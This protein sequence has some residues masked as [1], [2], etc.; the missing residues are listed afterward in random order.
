M[1]ECEG[2]GSP[3][4]TRAHSGQ[5][6][7]QRRRGPGVKAGISPAHPFVYPG[8]TAQAWETPGP[9]PSHTRESRQLSDLT[10]VPLR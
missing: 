10:A 3:S 2:L 7:T 5:S 1:A 8:N 9:P 6:K 4:L